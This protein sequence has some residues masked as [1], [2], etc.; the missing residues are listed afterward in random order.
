MVAPQ[1]EGGRGGTCGWVGQEARRDSV[2]LTITVCA[3]MVL[4]AACVFGNAKVSAS[5]PV[6][7]EHL[8]QL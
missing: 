7:V 1:T 4:I 5:S 2:R 8:E 6:S 3:R